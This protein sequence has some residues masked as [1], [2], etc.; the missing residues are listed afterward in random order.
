MLGT[1]SS[2]V[3][4]DLWFYNALAVWKEPTVNKQLRREDVRTSRRSNEKWDSGVF[5]YFQLNNRLRLYCCCVSCV[6]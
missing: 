1:V 4:H 3:L 2:F 6:W 5:F